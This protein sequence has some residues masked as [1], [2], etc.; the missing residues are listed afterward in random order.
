VRIY[1][2]FASKDYNFPGA[3]S[4][5]LENDIFYLCSGEFAGAF[6]LLVYVAIGAAK[7]TNSTEFYFH[8]K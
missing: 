8:G 7:I 3:Q 6:N 1:G 5:G 4:L 2:R